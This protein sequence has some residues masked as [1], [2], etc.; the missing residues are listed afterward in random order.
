MYT[1]TPEE[2]GASVEHLRE[3]VVLA[4]FGLIGVVNRWYMG[5]TTRSERGEDRRDSRI[6]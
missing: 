3:I 1:H 5:E 6:W 4:V 2:E